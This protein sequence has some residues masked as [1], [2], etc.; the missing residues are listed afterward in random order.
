M[1]YARLGKVITTDPPIVMPPPART[2]MLPPC[3]APPELD[4]LRRSPGR[5]QR[6]AVWVWGYVMGLLMGLAVGSLGVAWLLG[7]WP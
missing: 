2:P 3:Y 5:L 6:V 1:S 4:D 7:V